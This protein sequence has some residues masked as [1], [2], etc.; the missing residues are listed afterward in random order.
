MKITPLL[1][2]ALGV[3][4]C[5]SATAQ[6][7][8]SGNIVGYYNKALYGGDN[9]IANQLSNTD[10]ALNTLFPVGIAEGSTFTKWDPV[11]LKFLPASVFNEQT[12]WSINY[13]FTYGEGGLFHTPMT[14]TNTF[15]GG[16]WPWFNA[17]DSPFSPP[18]VSGE[19]LFLLSC[20][21][22][23]NSA[24]FDQ[25]VGRNPMEGEWVTW[26]NASAQ[27]WSTT[28]FCDGAWDNGEPLLGIGESAFFSLG[29][30]GLTP[31]IIPEAGTLGTMVLGGFLL[32]WFRRSRQG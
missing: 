6:N 11:T 19:G 10:N 4:L 23:L 12:G 20:V 1:A 7:P 26:L 9:L 27:E 28:T 14:F 3:D 29:P 8:Y 31:S 17:D 22:P 30:T 18:L 24:A 32:G 2:L 5:V 25:V 16:V 21:V 15:V 13:S